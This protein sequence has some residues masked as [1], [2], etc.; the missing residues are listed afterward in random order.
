MTISGGIFV[1]QQVYN[2]QVAKT[3]PTKAPAISPPI[4]NI[5]SVNEGGSV[6]INVNTFDYEG[7][8]LYWTIQGVTGTINS[9]D[10]TNFSGSFTVQANN[11]G[12]FTITTVA[13]NTTEGTESF[14]VQIRTDSTS[15]S[16]K[17]TS[18]TI[19]IND[20]SLDPPQ[21][22]GWFGGGFPNTATVDRID[23]N[24]DG[25]TAITRGSL[26]LA[27][28]ALAATGNASFGW[29]GGGNTPS[30]PGHIS[31]IDRITFA[32]DTSTASNRGQLGAARG[33]LAATGNSSFG[34]FGGGF[35]PGPNTLTRVDRITFSSDTGTTPARG[36]LSLARLTLDATGNNDFGWFGAGLLLSPS[37]SVVHSTV[38]RITYSSDT[39]TAS[40]RGPLS[41]VKRYYSATG[42]SSFGWFAGGQTGQG[43]APVT[44][45]TIDRINFASDTAA[46]PARGTLSLARRAL[47]ATGNASFGWFGGGTTGPSGLST[48]DR[49][50]FSSD[51]IT[52][53]LRGPLAVGRF[54]VVSTSNVL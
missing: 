44:I 15:G 23:F 22:Y 50:T 6:I 33:Y 42:T 1:L 48:V 41:A 21:E 10:F 29:F 49:L 14:V 45:S 31:L 25:V 13:D 54:Y 26:S 7:Q 16:I 32:S 8:T 3:W 19:T 20:T 28:R 52:A 9:S 43:P 30:S 5:S 36:P 35:F 47:A 17:A 34:W 12:T 18:G 38:D 46:A 27:R 4:T 40:V 11:F 53:S 51:T 37:P 2:K 39:N 24:N